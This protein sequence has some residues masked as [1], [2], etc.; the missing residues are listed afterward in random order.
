MAA[1]PDAILIVDTSGRILQNNH[2]TEHLFGYAERSMLGM[3]VDML[4][5]PTLRE[6]HAKKRKQFAF[7]PRTRVMGTNNAPLRCM[8][9][10]GNEFLAD[11]S[12]GSLMFE[13]QQCV[14]TLL[15][16][17]TRQQDEFARLR[18]L[19][20]DHIQRGLLMNA[21]L[22][23]T[24]SMLFALQR[25]ANGSYI[26]AARSDTC[27]QGLHVAQDA[28]PADWMQQWFNRVVPGDLPHVISAIETAAL[29][30]QALQLQW[31]HHVPGRGAQALQLHSGKP[32]A[33]SNGSQVWVCKVTPGK[34]AAHAQ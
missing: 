27:A 9:R 22:A 17:V 15:R 19:D 6:A 10:Y 33:L 21:L 18:A 30:H 16:T 5:P 25:N 20:Q 34:E 23:I 28:T 2:A 3:S 32:E 7:A 14:V 29:N 1:V 4:I 11:V 8:H 24:P 13:G 12:I 26:C 31:N